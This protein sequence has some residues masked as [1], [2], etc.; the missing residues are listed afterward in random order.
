MARYI[1][2]FVEEKNSLWGKAFVLLLEIEYAPGQMVRW[3]R[4]SED[5]ED[6]IVF[7]GET[8]TAFRM[9]NPRRP[10]SARGEIPTFEIAL[11][12][13]LRRFGSTIANTVVEGRPGRLITVHRD[14]LANPAAADAESFTIMSAGAADQYVTLTCRGVRFNVSR[15]RVSRRTVNR[16]R[17][18][19]ALGLA[20]MNQ[21]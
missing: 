8:Y 21:R 18:P 7:D 16:R 19:G 20:R 11:A 5:F 15:A 14:H 1:P 9:T 13:P 17:Y 4:I 10:K 2:D 6:D 12:N 3:A